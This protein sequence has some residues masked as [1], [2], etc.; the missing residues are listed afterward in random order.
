MGVEFLLGV[1]IGVPSEVVGAYA[2]LSI[3][4]ASGREAGA[5]LW[6]GTAIGALGTAPGVWLGGRA[7]GGDGSFGWTLIGSTAGTGVAAALLGIK[8]T[9]ATLVFAATLPIFG[10][11]AGYELSS[12]TRRTPTPDPEPHRLALTVVPTIGPNSVGLAGIF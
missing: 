3:D 8:S 7:M 2:G 6:I 9:Q 4:V 12:H 11:V 5:G 10:A 1:G